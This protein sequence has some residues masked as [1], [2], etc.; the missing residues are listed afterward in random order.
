M[1]VITKKGDKGKTKVR[2]KM[3]DKSSQIIETL[4]GIDELNC[5]L[6]WLKVYSGD[7]D[8][9][10]LQKDL[11]LI[12]GY[13][14]CKGEIDLVKRIEW[15]ESEIRVG[16][17]KLPALKNFLVPGLNKQEAICQICRSVSRRVERSL[18]RLNKYIKLDK[19]ILV[20]FNRLSDYLFILARRLT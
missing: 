1:S 16:E 9:E 13:L 7:K 10:K 11:W 3:V 15:L 4:G 12:S 20:Y 2:G 14:A 18:W 8:V 6:G 19:S 5:F 17:K